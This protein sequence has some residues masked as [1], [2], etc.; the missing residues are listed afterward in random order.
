VPLKQLYRDGWPGQL[1]RAGQLAFSAAQ[2]C[3]HRGE[4]MI[5]TGKGLP[6][7]KGSLT[8]S[9]RLGVREWLSGAYVIGGATPSRLTSNLN[10]DAVPVPELYLAESDV[11]VVLGHRQGDPV[12][13]HVVDDAER[14]DR[15]WLHADRARRHLEPAGFGHLVP[16]VLEQRAV[17]GMSM[18]VQKRLRGH[19]VRSSD[20]SADELE[21]HVVAALQPLR[22]LAA[23][24]HVSPAGADDAL[25]NNELMRLAVNPRIAEAVR[26][27]LAA[28]REW[29]GRWQHPAVLAHGDYWFSNLLF[30]AGSPPQLTG[31]IDWE[32]SRPDACAG[33][34]ALHLVM[35]SFSAW[36][37]TTPMQMLCMLW[38]D[39]LEPVLERLVAEAGQATGLD[40]EDLRY[41]ALLIWLLHLSRYAGDMPTWSDARCRDWLEE[42]ADS[43][44]RWL[45]RA[46]PSDPHTVEVDLKRGIHT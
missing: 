43:A 33:F 16:P 39:V 23:G 24:A 41:V 5:L 13:V 34:D 38:D 22:A 44:Q 26:L 9:S 2:W 29:S 37:G 35:F 21:Q 12:V 3:L 27:P 10:L 30:A 8:V 32:R 4:V 20:L 1:R 36:R 31:M 18:L 40:I 28:L 6:G 45:V 15:Y 14:L 17:L 25:L 11:L 42:P 7:A 46:S 19:I